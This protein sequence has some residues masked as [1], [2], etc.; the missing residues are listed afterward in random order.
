MLISAC[1]CVCTRRTA[2]ARL[3]ADRGRFN[4]ARRLL[5]DGLDSYP[6]HT[7]ALIE[8]ARTQ[9]LAGQLIDAQATLRL[10][11]KVRVIYTHTHSHTHT[12]INLLS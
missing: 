9:R 5:E 1:L 8:L 4:A 7:P 2:L 6:T 3:E 11:Q 10:A 12:H